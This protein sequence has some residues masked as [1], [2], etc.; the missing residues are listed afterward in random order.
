MSGSTPDPHCCSV[1]Q[2]NGSQGSAQPALI[3]AAYGSYGPLVMVARRSSQTR[4]VATVC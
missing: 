4:Y 2:S 3:I 1:H